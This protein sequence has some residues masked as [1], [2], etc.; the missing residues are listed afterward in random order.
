MA[1]QAWML[2]VIDI[3]NFVNKVFRVKWI[4]TWS[5]LKHVRYACIFQGADVRSRLEIA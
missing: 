4:D 3:Y 2:G 1:D 5:Y